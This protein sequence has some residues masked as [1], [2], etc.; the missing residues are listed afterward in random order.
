[1]FLGK[2]PIVR[3]TLFRRRC[4]FNS[5]IS[6]ANSQAGQTKVI[7]DLMRTL[8]RVNL[9]LVLNR[10]FFNRGNVIMN[11]LK[12]LVSIVSM[13]SLYVILLSKN[14]PRYFTLFI[15]ASNKSEYWESSWG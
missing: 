7:A 10:S 14:T 3:R 4:N 12:A 2:L 1:V 13:Y 11:V 5:W 9:T 6:A 8:W 15:N